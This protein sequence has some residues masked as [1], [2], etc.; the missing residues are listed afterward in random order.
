[1]ILIPEE[2]VTESW[3]SVAQLTPAEA[4][5]SIRKFG[6]RQPA[7]L[8]YALGT[9]ESLSPQAG[10]LLVY[11]A[12]VVVNAVYVS[13]AKVSQVSPEAIEASEAAL[14]E[15]LLT[16]QGAHDAF[17]ARAGSVL[18]DRQPHLFRYLVET[19][20]EAPY[21][22]PDPVPLT[23]EEQGAIFLAIATV[24]LALDQQG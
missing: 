1:M 14:E 5:G 7:L 11:I 18:A 10:E 24:I 23:P 22:P 6:R 9:S 12:F 4:K 3:Q 15:R 20:Q 16:L 17:I 13:G 2:V 19:L 8:A 21:E